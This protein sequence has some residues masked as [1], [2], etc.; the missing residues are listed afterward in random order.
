MR[1]FALDLRRRPVRV[2]VS[3]HR[4]EHPPGMRPH[5]VRYG[6][7][8]G[9]CLVSKHLRHDVIDDIERQRF[10]SVHCGDCSNI[11]ECLRFAR[12]APLPRRG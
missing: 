9:F 4:Q 12:S 2:L 1:C 5:P 8:L 3:K 7:P 10:I 6:Q 11:L